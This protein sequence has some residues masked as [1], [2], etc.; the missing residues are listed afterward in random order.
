LIKISTPLSK[1]VTFSFSRRMYDQVWTN[2]DYVRLQLY[3][4]KDGRALAA[5]KFCLHLACVGRPQTLELNP[6]KWEP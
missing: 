3:S 4:I 6:Q 5:F 1:W 2:T